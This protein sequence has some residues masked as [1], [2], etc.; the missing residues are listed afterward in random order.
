[1]PPRPPSPAGEFDC[2]GVFA[3]FTVAGARAREGSHVLFSSQDFPGVIPDHLVA[4]A[5]I[6]DEHPDGAAEDWSTP[7]T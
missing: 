6:A 5:A 7:G 2:V 1:M 3:P 4:T